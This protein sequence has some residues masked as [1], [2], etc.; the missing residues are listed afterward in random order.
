MLQTLSPKFSSGCYQLS[1]ILIFTFSPDV[2]RFSLACSA[3]LFFFAA[4]ESF[5]LIIIYFWLCWAFTAVCGLCLVAVSEGYSLLRCTGCSP[6]W[7][8]L[9]QSA[10]SRHLGSVVAASRLGSCG[11]LGWVVPQHMGSSRIRGWTHVPCL[12]RQIIIHCAAREVP[13]AEKS[14]C[15]G[16]WK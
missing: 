1:S 16:L 7:L 3:I 13:D 2:H 14:F 10:G 11:A 5:F 6:W 4:S 15:W 9:L 8:L 12:G